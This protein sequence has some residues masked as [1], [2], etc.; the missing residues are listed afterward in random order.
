M[1][2]TLVV[3]LDEGSQSVCLSGQ[4]TQAALRAALFGVE[5]GDPSVLVSSSQGDLQGGPQSQTRLDL[6][7]VTLCLPLLLLLLLQ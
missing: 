3:D 7:A 6:L 5:L 1:L 2:L 4:Q